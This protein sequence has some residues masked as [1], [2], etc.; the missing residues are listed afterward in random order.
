MGFGPSEDTMNDL[1]KAEDELEELAGPDADEPAAEVAPAEAVVPSVMAGFK[2]L[3]WYEL[4]PL[5]TK[6]STSFTCC[7]VNIHA[8]WRKGAARSRLR[9]A[10]GKASN[11]FHMSSIAARPVRTFVLALRVPGNI[12]TE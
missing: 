3:A 7:G 2:K 5:C 8:N 12:G 9:S 10:I 6:A 1:A 11:F 4:I